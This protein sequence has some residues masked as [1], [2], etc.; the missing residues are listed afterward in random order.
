MAL[1]P[2]ETIMCDPYGRFFLM[3]P[4]GHLTSCVLAP[5]Y[6]PGP[7]PLVI[8]PPA[9]TPQVQASLISFVNTVFDQQLRPNWPEKLLV[10]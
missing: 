6:C 1:Q 3:G 7:L 9:Q 8:F 2:A 5:V 10:S 4:C